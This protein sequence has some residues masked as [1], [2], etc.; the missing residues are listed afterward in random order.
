MSQS[1]PEGNGERSAA[2]PQPA[3]PPEAQAQ[4]P[5]SPDRDQ[6]SP[7]QPAEADAGGSAPAAEA[8]AAGPDTPARP[9]PKKRSAKRAAKAGQKDQHGPSVV[10][11][12]GLMR[13]IGRFRH[14]LDDAPVPGD[15]LVLRTDRGVELGEVVVNVGQETRYGCV[16]ESSLADYLVANGEQYPFQREGKVLRRANAQDVIDQRHLED[17]AREEAAFCREQI[18]QLNLSMKLVSVEHL[19]GGERII[20]N[21]SAESRVDFRE[22]VRRLAREYR[23]RIEMHQVGAR[24]EARLLADYERCGRQCC[25]RLFIKD[26]KPVSMRMAKV[27]KATLDPSKISGR[28]GRLMCCLRFE[29]VSYEE[30]RA[31]LPKK[32]VWVRTDRHIGR[33]TETQILTQLVKLELPDKSQAV[34]SNEEIQHRYEA[35]PDE[36]EIERFLTQARAAAALVQKAE[37]GIFEQAGD[38]PAEEAVVEGEPAAQ[39]PGEQRKKK[40][41]RRRRRKKAVAGSAVGADADRRPDRPAAPSSKEAGQA[42]KKQKRPP[43]RRKRR[44]KKTAR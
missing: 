19:L 4:R 16:T 21:F 2:S 10:A 30:L 23:T 39:E 37:V 34:V 14:N 43:R 29:D 41:R 22:L 26:L 18:R 20:F 40:K 32:N 8:P 7:P 6:V 42:K 27:Q 13:N 11:R 9:A 3:K 17:S 5:D 44:K 1:P 33:V 31:L 15:K 38:Q 12:Y 28:C 36:E 35:R 24:D 25:C